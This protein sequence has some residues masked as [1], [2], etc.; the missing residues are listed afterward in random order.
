M[1]LVPEWR[2]LWRS[3]SVQFQAAAA[4]FFIALGSMTDVAIEVWRNLPD[5]IRAVFPPWFVYGFGV[6][7]IVG[8]ILSKFYVQR[9]L[10]EARRQAE[11]G[12]SGPKP[13]QAL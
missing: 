9:K 1:K 8:G 5:D 13:D 11:N 7:L 2:S 3:H 6:A 12:D 4:A 10:T